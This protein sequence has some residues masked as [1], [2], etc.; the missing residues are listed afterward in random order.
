MNNQMIEFRGHFNFSFLGSEDHNRRA[1]IK[2]D[3]DFNLV[4]VTS[5]WLNIV[6]H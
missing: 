3:N 4:Y 1:Y 6:L 2:D 5:T